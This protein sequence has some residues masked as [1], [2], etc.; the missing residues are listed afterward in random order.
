[1]PPATNANGKHGEKLIAAQFTFIYPTPRC[2]FLGKKGQCKHCETL[3]KSWNVTLNQ[4]PHLAGC[5]GWKKY[6]ADHGLDTETTRKKQ[7]AVTDFFATKDSTPEELFA[8]AVYTSTC[9][10]SQFNTPE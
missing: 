9:S 3:P 7:P 10:F 5:A 2:G 1:M 4:G 6:Q 8:L